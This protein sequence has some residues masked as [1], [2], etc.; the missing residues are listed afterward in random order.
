L[1]RHKSTTAAIKH[2]KDQGFAIWVADFSEE[3][4]IPEDVPLDRPI[5][6]W[7]GAELAGVSDEALAAADGVITIPMSGFSQSL[8]ISVAAAVILY[9]ISQRIRTQLGDDSRLPEEERASLW[10]MWLAREKAMRKGIQERSTL[11]DPVRDGD[12]NT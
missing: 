2:L 6:I 5:C 11:L 7:L 4:S 3:A 8:N 12:R 10:E 9:S 1:H